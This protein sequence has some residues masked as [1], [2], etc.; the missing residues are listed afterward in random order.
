MKRKRV[1]SDGVAWSLKCCLKGC[2]IF[3]CTDEM[4]AII[5]TSSVILRCGLDLALL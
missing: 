5:F 2:H 4:A 3:Q 1:R